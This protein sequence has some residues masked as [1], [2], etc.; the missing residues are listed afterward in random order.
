MRSLFPHATLPLPAL[1]PAMARAGEGRNV[2][3]TTITTLTRR[4]RLVVFA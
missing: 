2:I 1:S 4:V 3:T